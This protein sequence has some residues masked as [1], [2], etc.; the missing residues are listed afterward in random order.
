MNRR[1]QFVFVAWIFTGSLLFAQEGEKPSEIQIV[2]YD[3]VG[4]IQEEIIS[5]ERDLNILP[6][7]Q[8]SFLEVGSSQVFISQH[9]KGNGT[10]WFQVGSNNQFELNQKGNGNTHEGR[11]SGDENIIR[12]VQK[13]KNNYV[14][15]DLLGDGMKLEIVQKGQNHEFIQIEK[16]GTSPSYKVLQEGNSGM[17]VTIDHEKY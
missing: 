8:Q 14:F 2:E 5:P 10:Y 11:L 16:D 7:E 1:I 9:G 17:K 6:S 13:G 15:Q 3:H 12:V 4:A